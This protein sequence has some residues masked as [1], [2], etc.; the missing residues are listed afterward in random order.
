MKS[1]I[2]TRRGA[3]GG[4]LKRK[5][6]KKAYGFTHRDGRVYFHSKEDHSDF[7]DYFDE[8]TVADVT[9]AKGPSDFPYTS[10]EI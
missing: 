4:I 5:T 3:K 2:I 7:V 10:I 9:E 6:Y 8:R 1:F